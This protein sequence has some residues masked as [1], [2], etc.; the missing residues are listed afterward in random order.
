MTMFAIEV[1]VLLGAVWAFRESH[2]AVIW[3]Y[4]AFGLHFLTSIAAVFFA[5]IFKITRL[6]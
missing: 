5:F 2:P 1:M 6:I 3:S 4:V